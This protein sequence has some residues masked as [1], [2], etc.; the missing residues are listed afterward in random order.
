MSRKQSYKQYDNQSR[1]TFIK[2][3]GA[4]GTVGITTFAGCV[5]NGN[6]NGNGNGDRV[7][8]PDGEPV[9]E[10]EYANLDA[11][12]AVRF[13]YGED[14]VNILRDIGFEVEYTV[15]ALSGYLDKVFVERDFD[16]TALRWLDGYD[17]DRPLRDTSHSS[18]LTPGSGNFAGHWNPEY[19]E[20]VE[21]QAREP[22]QDARQE[23]VHEAQRYLVEEEFVT[24][25]ILVDIRAMPYNTNRMSGIR[26][27]L[28][29]GIIEVQNMI[30]VETPDGELRASQQEDLTT[31]NPTSAERGRADRDHIR[32]LFDRLMF[33]DPDEGYLPQPWAAETVEQPDDTT[34]EVR[35]R[36]GLEFHD[37]EPLTTEDIEF[38]Y[39]YGPEH[40]SSFAGVLSNLEEITVETDLDITF[41]LSTPDATF[42]NRG[43]AG[44]EASILPKHILE[45][46]DPDGWDRDD[47]PFIGSGPFEFVQ[48][49]LAEELILE[50]HDAHQFAPNIDRY[51]RI[52][53]SDGPSAASALEEGS[54]DMVPYDL[55]PD[56]LTR[57]EE[58]DGIEL[59]SPLMTSIHYATYN[60]WPSYN[61]PFQFRE[62]RRAVAHTV[63]H[64]EWVDIA[65]GGFA[66]PLDTLMSPGLE[67]WV[68]DDV[69][70]PQFDTDRAREILSE[71]GFQWDQDGRLHYPEN[72][73]ENLTM[74]HET[75]N[76]A[77][78][79]VPEELQGWEDHV[80][81]V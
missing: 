28:E 61:S 45:G 81:T 42:F 18:T 9:P 60:M 40:N 35:L 36:E 48:W 58:V 8:D 20:L 41:E 21:A 31:L 52:Q 51:V 3:A 25:P 50:S 11:D 44:R 33:P 12:F 70:T 73:K 43:M 1:R 46:E 34:I 49:D 78:H 7:D 2:A 4:S 17:P 53:A 63:P 16:I 39:T 66:E 71:A 75:F 15:R 80:D 13:Y 6:G 26:E 19:D 54:V 76:W 79:D 37:G 65:A 38:T 59:S 57:L 67:F 32:L 14:W 77:D 56:Q 68:A 47:R 5:G 24:T 69:Q 62:V 64:Q 23:L 27:L 74:Q 22:D 10:I 30:D 55:P 72:P 29:N